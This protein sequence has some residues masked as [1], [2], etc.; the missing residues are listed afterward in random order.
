MKHTFTIGKKVLKQLRQDK[1]FF[2]LSIVAPLI[3]IGFFKLFADAMPKFPPFPTARY[4]VP[5]A[6]FV[7]HF[8][9]FILCAIV[10]VQ[11]RTAGTLER[12]F[13]NG[14]SR[15]SVIGGYTIGYFSLATLQA[16]AVLAETIWLFNLEYDKKIIF[17]LFL[18]IWLLAIVSVM[19]GIF[20]STFARHE[21]HVFPFIPLIILPS[22]FLSGLL[23]DVSALPTWAQVIGH[24][25]P[26]YYAN[27][28]IQEIIQPDYNLAN[29]YGDFAI[30]S[31][32]AL[33]LL[34]IASFTLK[35]VE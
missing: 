15:I 35:E 26:L 8:L 20:V 16:L 24:G 31:G 23:L 21:G 33:V 10:L 25:F 9:S 11:E 17:L 34:V 13:V 5:I 29:T 27:N 6:A 19:L 3:I 7:V 2:M 22:V 1:R 4:A 28:I 14:V 30:L 32:Y 18:V 12:M